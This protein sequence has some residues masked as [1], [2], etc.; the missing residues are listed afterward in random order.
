M[1]KQTLRRETGVVLKTNSG[2][3]LR[4]NGCTYGARYEEADLVDATVFPDDSLEIER[5]KRR[6]AE[7]LTVH[8]VRVIFTKEIYLA[9]SLEDMM[10]HDG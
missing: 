10:A 5:A 4:N 8:N 7:R 2:R 6:W 9:T 3:Y 1:A